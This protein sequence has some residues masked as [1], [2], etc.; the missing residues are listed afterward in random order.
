M[1]EQTM[2]IAK[3]RREAK[4]KKDKILSKEF[5]EL[6]GTVRPDKK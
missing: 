6:Q 2:K 5:K 1:S 3:K 4:A